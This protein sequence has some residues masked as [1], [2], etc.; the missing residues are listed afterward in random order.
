M[1]LG[2]KQELELEAKRFFESYKKE[3]FQAI[4]GAGQIVNI[5]FDLIS[6]F[7]PM[8]AEKLLEIPAEIIPLLE[9]SLDETGLIKNPLI[10]LANWPNSL[11][12]SLKDIRAK[13]LD[14]LVSLTGRIIST[15]DPSIKIRNIRFE[16]PNCGKIIS[17]LQ[18]TDE[19][20]YPIKCSCGRKS[21]FNLLSKELEDVKIIELLD[22][23]NKII[24]IE[25]GARFFTT[26]FEEILK[27]GNKVEICAIVDELIDDSNSTIVRWR[28][29]P[30]GLKLIGQEDKKLP[31]EELFKSFETIGKT[32]KG[33]AFQEFVA[34][35]F[36]KKGYGV[37]R[38]QKTG[39]FG[40]DIIAQKD[41]E[42]IAIQCKMFKEDT[43][44]SNEVVQNA[45]GASQSPYSSN[46]VIIVTTAK[47]FTDSAKKQKENSKIPIELWDKE[48]VIAEVHAHMNDLEEGIS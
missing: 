40:I 2:K 21:N 26:Y 46:K 20:K 23:N 41:K 45:L 47:G 6:N 37:K 35:L 22:T 15:N 18:L 19:I 31:V 5:D 4:K 30:V 43:K 48:K 16:C 44:V 14:T 1:E 36:E 13:N 32:R 39:D 42:N 24:N 28:L 34:K 38:I 3:I 29:D 17:C 11:T 8:L 12:L 10:L 33:F 27:M 7:S 9:L 25:F